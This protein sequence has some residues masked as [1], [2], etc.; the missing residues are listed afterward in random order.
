MKNRWFFALMALLLSFSGVA[1]NSYVIPVCSEDL[2]INYMPF[3]ANYIYSAA[4]S[5]YLQSDIAISGEITSI[6]YKST[7]PA[8]TRTV[9]VYLA[10]TDLST[11]SSTSALLA[12]EEFT[13]VFSGTITTAENGWFTITF[14]TPFE[15]SNEHNLVVGFRD[16]TG[17]SVT[18]YPNFAASQREGGRSYYKNST[19]R[20]YDLNESGLGSSGKVPYI[21]LGIT[22]TESYCAAVDVASCSSLESTSITMTWD[23]VGG[24]TGYVAECKLPSETW[25]NAI[26]LTTSNTTVTFT[27]LD[28]NTIYDVRVQNACGSSWFTTTCRTACGA[29]SEL[30][31]TDGFET[32]GTSGL[33]PLTCWNPLQTYVASNG[34]FPGAYCGYSQ[35]CHSGQNSMEFKGSNILIGLPNFEESIE[36]LRLTFYANTTSSSAT[37][38]SLGVME[39]G[40]LTDPLDASS[41]VVLDT[42]TGEAFSR[43]G[44][45]LVGPYDFDDFS[46]AEYA[47]A[48][49]AIRYTNSNTGTS[50]NLDDFTVTLIPSCVAPNT[51]TI[52]DITSTTAVVNWTD[53]NSS[54]NAWK[55]YYKPVNDAAYTEVSVTGATTWTLEN[56]VP[57]TQYNVYLM[58]DCGDEV[59]L[60]ATSVV[61]FTT[62][63]GDITELPYLLDFNTAD[64]TDCFETPLHS[65]YTTRTFPL[66]TMT[67]SIAHNNSAGAMEFLGGN[68]VTAL[69]PTAEDITSLRVKLFARCN[70][71]SQANAGTIEIGYLTDVADYTTFVTL[72]TLPYMGQNRYD[73]F[74]YSFAAAEVGSRMAIR[75][76]SS[77]TT[78]SWY[79][80]DIEI[81]YIP[82]CPGPNYTSLTAS[83]S[84]DNEYYAD[85][86]WTDVSN[87]AWRVYYKETADTAYENY[88]DVTLP[89][90]SIAVDPTSTYSFYVVALCGTEESVDATVERTVSVP[91]LPVDTVPFVEDFESPED[92][93]TFSMTSQAPANAWI[94]GN[95]TFN[96]GEDGAESG[97]SMYVSNDGQSFAASTAEYSS[98]S[99]QTTLATMVV[100]FPDEAQEYHL[101]FD[102]KVGGKYMYS[103]CYE[104]MKV[105]LVDGTAEVNGTVPEPRVTLL[106]WQHDINDWTH[107]DVV[108]DDV[109]G[110]TKQIVFAYKTYYYDYYHGTTPAAVDNVSIY[111][112]VCARAT[113]VAASSLESDAITVTWQENG[114]ATS[115]NVYYKE[116]GSSD[117]Y[118]MTTA[119]GTAQ[120][121]ISGLQPNTSY[122][123]YVEAICSNGSLAAAS[124]VATLKTA[125]GA[126]ADLPWTEDF[127]TY[128]GSNVTKPIDCW[129]SVV[130]YTA[131]NGTFPG[132]YC[133]YAE[134]AHSGQ[135]SVEIKGGTGLLALPTFEESVENLRLTFFANTTAGSESAAGVMEVGVITDLS[136]PTSFVTLDTVRGEAFNRNGANLV[137]PYDFNGFTGAQYMDARLALR[138]TNSSTG[139][140]W[141]LD[142]FTV[143]IIPACP[144]PSS[145]SV[146]I[147]D[148]TAES[149][150]ISWEDEDESHSAWTVYYR[151]E[152]EEDW[153]DISASSTSVELV[154]LTENTKYFIYIMTDCGDDDNIDRTETKQFKTTSI[155]VDVPYEET[156]ESPEDVHAFVMTN[157]HAT[158]TW[159]IGNATFNPG[160]E[161][162]TEGY[163]MYVSNNNGESFTSSSAPSYD[164]QHS[165]AT[166]TVEFPEDEL[167]YHIGFDFKVGGKYMYSSLYEGLKVYMVDGD[168]VVDGSIPE[169]RVTVMDWQHDINNWTHFDAMLEGVAGTTKQFVFAYKVYASYY[170]NDM[171]AA[172][173]N[174][175][176]Y[177]KTCAQPSNVTVSDVTSTEATVSWTENGDAT[178]W[179]VFY[180][181]AADTEWNEVPAQDTTAT[182]SINPSTTYTVKVIANCGSSESAYSD[183]VIFRSACDVVTELPYIMTFED[184]YGSDCMESALT[185]TYTSDGR[186]FPL[187][188]LASSIA[189]NGSAGAMEFMSGNI[190]TAFPATQEDITSLR[191]KLYARCGSYSETYAGLMEIGYIT[192][193]NDQTSF[194][195]MDTIPYMGQNRYDMF[196]YNFATAESG[197]RIAIRYTSS[198]TTTS[199]YFDDVTI[200]LI[201]SCPGP[202]Y[203]S[204]TASVSYDNAYTA[205]LSWTDAINSAW[206]VYYKQSTDS[207][208]ENYVDVAETN[209]SISVN[210]S[211]TYSFYVVAL[212]GQTESVDAT[213]ERTVSV[214]GLP[215]ESLPYEQDFETSETITEFTITGSGVNQWAIGDNVFYSEEGAET[216][217][218]LYISNDNGVTNAYTNNNTSISYATIIVPFNEQMEYHVSF[219]YKCV[220]ESSTYDYMR[221]FMLN[222]DEDL[223]TS[224]VPS[225]SK[226]VSPRL[227]QISNWTHYDYML[228]GVT[229][230]SLK[231]IVFAWRNDGSLGTNPPAAID[232]INIYGNT[233]AKV[234]NVAL[235]S[236]ESDAMTVTWH[237]NGTAT[238]WNAY[239]KEH[240]TSD[241]YI[242]VQAPDQNQA[243]FTDLQPNTSYD[244]Y[245]EAVCEDGSIAL[246]S[247]VVSLKTACGAITTL[248]WFDDFESYTG[249]NT[250]KPI[251]CWTNIVSYSASNGTFPAVYC[252]YAQAAHSGVNSV[253]FK[254][255]NNLVALPAFAEPIENLRLTFY[256]NTSASTEAAAGTFEVGIISDM[257]DASSFIVLDTVTGVALSR[258][259]ANLVGPFDF[260]GMETIP[261]GSL[262]A[263]RFTNTSTGVSWNL[264]DFT[265]TLIP[266]CAAPNTPAVT[267]ITSTSATVN[268][269]DDNTEHNAWKLYYKATSDAQYTEVS[270]QGTTSWTLQNLTPS[271]QYSVYLMSDCG[272]E[273][274]LETTATVTFST[275]CGVVAEFPYT[276][277]FDNGDL[278]CWTT[279]ALVGSTAW[280]C[281]N[282]VHSSGTHSAYFTYVNNAS[283]RLI[284]P[285]F[286]MTSLEYPT[287]SYAYYVRNYTG[288][289]D[290]L[291]VYYRTSVNDEWT[292]IAGHGDPM[293]GFL[294]DTVSL[295][296]PS[297]TYQV[298]FL[299]LGRNAYGTFVDNITVFEGEAQQPCT[300][301]SS[302]ISASI[303]AGETYT[304]NGQTLTTAGTYTATLVNAA[305]CD[306]TVTLTLTVNAASASSIEATICAGETYTFNGQPLTAAGTYTATLQN[307][308][309]CDSVVTL[310]LT[311]NA[312]STS[313]IEATICE[314][315]TYTFNG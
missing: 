304:F 221:V 118:D 121:Y 273:P 100:A 152:N 3:R 228:T 68:L 53:D 113:N 308:N 261:A 43:N 315:E 262:I 240:G 79:F 14:D 212:C 252:G 6:S 134:A 35:A 88:V 302:T 129:T 294:T 150:T 19:S 285:E 307:V 202:D 175:S 55:L 26:S 299:G 176:I 183:P 267:D 73:M 115:W 108:L 156:F 174:V 117:A 274:N 122:D 309:G 300:P 54:H 36:N 271:T 281:D 211:S 83:V 251:E 233:C 30:P 69:P 199:W 111:G 289:A 155:P 231:K 65:T 146:A 101:S 89:S 15:Y 133:G 38:T 167:E 225:D 85:L 298:M 11:F 109:A 237:E 51:P 226:A 200:E 22:S 49:I 58:S 277:G 33:Q 82:S 75:Y 288:S 34:T 286:D 239:Y 268:W 138:Y 23:A 246:P 213:M 278:G 72:D 193:V 66:V 20:A 158:N 25:D 169:P 63:C 67:S 310:T 216:G 195:A 287:L 17:S 227:S 168:A 29:I 91:G 247:D 259:G 284:S 149:A 160:E 272:E 305:G 191:M 147:S 186:V 110:T 112:N 205:E 47:N 125:C 16:M 206:R 254:G 142:D 244:V 145:S 95:A 279:E 45:N 92:V 39:V 265:V 8:V 99:S 266:S 159:V 97:Y 223:S 135:N 151:A 207:T 179:T 116:N 104:G 93:N 18:S 62:A 208:Y 215:L 185:S 303:C 219:D 166:I 12:P 258:N 269:T 313:S 106:D 123:V 311:V 90:A 249:S 214:P 139:V 177:G 230:G 232:N 76:T 163:S 126:I 194:V 70:S 119:T 148:I 291:G 187:T 2:T 9:E 31:W 270:V 124:D 13:Q 217:H 98:Y 48:Q 131:S 190:V 255:G 295:P 218:S 192:D 257:S 52:A 276:E 50:W 78:T 181:G 61:T 290:S 235:V 234:T 57:H 132:V 46:G 280:V 264:D 238:S 77:Y 60:D 210:P 103:T 71:S 120:A 114:T 203:T 209:A 201:P 241:D 102:Y 229:P 260:N 224:S 37:S 301:T 10:E 84:Y 296:N 182:I 56:L 127:E 188:T 5:I 164:Y 314:G 128:T 171:P 248:P 7:T 141:N 137:G 28:A 196:V 80:D 144:A 81:D 44:S 198:S 282:T 172:V 242:M 306:S 263:L 143:T 27:G 204:L 184:E 178:S 312:A 40:V 157:Q 250:A 189:R 243:T 173:D 154:G 283:A 41:F 275:T 32:Y 136:D 162:A 86:T 253:E 140:S 222:A 74:M 165:L 4:Q 220:A 256:A 130:S 94:I 42:V 170:H 197:S 96:P 24:A 161:E 107:F 236:A 105:Y 21:K 297:A 59:N 292:F 245:V 87:N 153:S 1:Q 180:K 64:G 293:T